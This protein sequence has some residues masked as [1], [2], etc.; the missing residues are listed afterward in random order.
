MKQQTDGVD[1]F[2]GRDR[3]HAAVEQPVGNVRGIDPDRGRAKR[4]RCLPR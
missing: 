1:E 2:M 3:K 4:K